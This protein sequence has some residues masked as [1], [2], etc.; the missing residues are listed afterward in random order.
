MLTAPVAE[1]GTEK[2]NAK[3]TLRLSDIRGHWAEKEISALYE[4][5]AIKANEQALFKPDEAITRGEL[6]TL[7]LRV[8]G[9]QPVSAEVSHFADIPL[10]N[11]LSTY[12]ET[13][14]RLGLVHG[15][16]ENDQLCLKPDEP[17]QKQEFLTILLRAKGVSGEVNMLPWTEV[18]ELLR[19]FADLLQVDEGNR[20][21]FAYAM[22][23][24]IISVPENGVLEP[25]KIMTRAEAAVFAYHNL[26]AEPTQD[27]PK[28]DEIET[29]YKQVMTVETSAYTE[30]ETAQLRQPGELAKTY[31][32]WPVR[33]GL[34]A[35]DP[36]VIPLGTH[37]YIEGYGYAVAADIGSGVKDAHV[38]LYFPSLETALA[39]GRQ[40]EIKVYLLD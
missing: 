38:D 23:K 12:A 30:Q 3:A 19:P 17:V 7:F 36:N 6:I 5:G 2:T 21:G 4:T 10:E 35:V 16:M 40:K 24:Q 13:A 26:F 14:Y 28:V 29:P 37:L 32:G 20:K 33:E 8:K 22:D 27:L 39:Y 1:A 34:V 18:S 9:I 15:A 25:Q 31:L 11:E